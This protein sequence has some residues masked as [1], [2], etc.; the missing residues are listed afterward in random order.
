ML[1]ELTVDL[2]VIPEDTIDRSMGKD[3]KW[4]YL[5]C[6]KI[7]MTNYSASTKYELDYKGTRYDSVTAEYV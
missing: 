3:G 4:Y 2:S 5:C 1:A 7:E 6:Y